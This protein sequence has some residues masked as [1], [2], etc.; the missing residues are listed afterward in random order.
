MRICGPLYFTCIYFTSIKNKRSEIS[1]CL[2]KLIFFFFFWFWF[3]CVFFFFFFF[4]V[5]FM[6]DHQFWVYWKMWTQVYIR[7]AGDL[8]RIAQ[9]SVNF[10]RNKSSDKV[11][12][13]VRLIFCVTSTRLSYRLI[14][15]SSVFFRCSWLAKMIYS[16]QT[17]LKYYFDMTNS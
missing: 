12:T 2:Y 11:I 13:Q 3:F 5:V 16:R 9:V 8:E 1:D 14:S 7:R 17:I 6:F 10:F 15:L 4:V